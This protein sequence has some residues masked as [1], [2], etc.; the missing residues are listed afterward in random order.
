[1]DK[2]ERSRVIEDEEV[3]RLKKDQQD[4]I[5]IIQEG[6]LKR[7]KKN[8]VGKTLAGRVSDDNRKVLLNKGKELTEED[9]DTL[10]RSYWGELR[11]DQESVDNEIQRIVDSMQE[12]GR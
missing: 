3:G 7:L 1:M 10:P 11:V 6:A 9:L 12:Q 5:R 2:D 4:E 8:L